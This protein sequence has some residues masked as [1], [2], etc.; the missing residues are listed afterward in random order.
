MGA[1]AYRFVDFLYEA[2]MTW[3]QLLPVGPTGMGDSP[4]SGFS[5]FAGNPYYI[6]LDLLVEDG[7]LEEKEVLDAGMENDSDK[8]DYETLRKKRMPLLRLAAQRADAALRQDVSTFCQENG[9]VNDYALYMAL[10]GYYEDRPWFEWEDEG[11][12]LHQPEAIKRYNELLQEEVWFHAFLQYVFDHQWSALK[13]YANKRGIRLFGDV[14]I[15]VSMD[16]ADVWSQREFFQLNAQGKAT[17]VAGVPPDAFSED[18]QLWGNPL[19]NWQAMKQDGYGWWIRRIDGAAKR[20]DCIRIDHFRGLESYWS[21][22]AD[23]ETAKVGLWEKGPG[24]DLIGVLNGWFHGLSFVAEDLGILTHDVRLLLR[25]SGWPGM[26]VLQFAFTDGQIS[27]YMPHNHERNSV[28]Y[29]GTHDNDTLEGWLSNS[30]PEDLAWASD[31]FGVQQKNLGEAMLH[32]CLTS[33][34]DTA[35]L[36]AQDLLGLGSEARTNVPGVADGNWRWR[37]KKGELTDS[38]AAQWA[39]VVCA[40]GRNSR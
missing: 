28:C 25:D 12:R 3:W 34:C 35:I 31:Y 7:L 37:L 40:T 30:S 38:I 2:K 13:Q 14:A 26:N 6:D 11:I 32:A 1:E 9:W 4:Y 27:S 36:C 39:R 10:K 24:M 8:V 18:G 15:Y 33:V 21:I 5:V 19:Y 16:S 23:S 20:Y 29:V 17:R 22:P